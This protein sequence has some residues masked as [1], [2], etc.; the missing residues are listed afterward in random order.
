MPK[1]ARTTVFFDRKGDQAMATRGAG[2]N[3]ALFTA[4]A[5]LPIVGC[6]SIDSVRVEQI[7]RSAAI[8]FVPAVGGFSA[9]PDGQ[10]DARL[11]TDAVFGEE[12]RLER[13]PAQRRIARRIGVG[14]HRSRQKVGQARERRLP[15]L[16]LHQRVVGLD[17][18]EPHA[19]RDQ[20]LAVRQRDLIA[21]RK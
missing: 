6:V 5:E 15:V 7:V 14:A 16:V 17:R 20:V 11:Q 19:G 2:R 1:P 18:L 9:K 12:R 3:F 13:P 10:L 21:D 8:L 4:S